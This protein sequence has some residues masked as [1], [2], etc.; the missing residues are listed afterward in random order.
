ME[1]GNGKMPGYGK[2]MKPD[3]I[4]DM[5]AYIRSWQSDLTERP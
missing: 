1:K 4:K 2:S 5:A 3:D